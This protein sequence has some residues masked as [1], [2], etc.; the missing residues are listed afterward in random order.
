[1]FE[2]G[3]GCN[4]QVQYV[5]DRHALPITRDYMAEAEKRLRSKSNG[6]KKKGPAQPRRASSSRETEPA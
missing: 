5:R 2:N 4:F 6:A 1:M 3:A